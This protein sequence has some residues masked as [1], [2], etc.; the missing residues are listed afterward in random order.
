MTQKAVIFDLFGTLVDNWPADDRK[1]LLAGMAAELGCAFESLFHT[2]D[3][4][5]GQRDTGVFATVEDCLCAA[6]E[7]METAATENQI[8]RAAALYSAFAVQC[9]TPR[10]DAVSTIQ[11]LRELGY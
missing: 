6:C 10:E 4:H 9:L 3:E 1:T 11:R 2:W 5:R 7:G 8:A